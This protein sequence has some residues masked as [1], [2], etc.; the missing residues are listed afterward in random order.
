MIHGIGIDICDNMRIKKLLVKY[1][2]KF[3]QRIF[4]SQEIEYCLKKGNP[5]PYLAARFAFK[6]AFFKALNP[7]VEISFQDIGLTGREGKKAVYT[8]DH[9]GNFL[10]NMNIQNIQFSISHERH[11]SI[12]TVILEK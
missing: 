3:L 10:K 8:S 11:Y 5:A 12:A 6:E 9:L 1:Q 7:A 4:I 2:H